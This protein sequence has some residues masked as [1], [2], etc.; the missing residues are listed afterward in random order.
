MIIE[1]LGGYVSEG[2]AIG[3]RNSTD[4]VTDAVDALGQ[5]AINQMNSTNDILDE[6]S[7]I[8]NTF[9]IRPVIDM[10]SFNELVDD[11]NGRW[12]I[13]GL[14]NL[15]SVSSFNDD[16]NTSS[17]LTTLSQIAKSLEDIASSNEVIANKEDTFNINSEITM[18]NK[19]V[20]RMTAKYVREQ[21]N[22]VEKINNRRRGLIW[23]KNILAIYHYLRAAWI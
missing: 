3:I 13:L 8:D 6:L 1:K 21:N 15:N 12:S 17:D 19:A 2:F 23:I 11:L 9:V 16:Y 22:K 20:G 4:L 18:D 10:D 7:S 14:R 5:N